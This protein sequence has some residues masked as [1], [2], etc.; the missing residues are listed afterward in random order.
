L[1][2]LPV[3]RVR[4]APSALRPAFRIPAIGEASIVSQVAS[5]VVSKTGVGDLIVRVHGHVEHGRA[6]V[7][8]RGGQEVRP[9]II[10]VAQPPGIR[11][12]PPTCVAAVARRLSAS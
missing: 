7:R 4:R 3:I 12:C 1:P 10:A 8:Y 6:A 9:R 2:V 5:R 11:T